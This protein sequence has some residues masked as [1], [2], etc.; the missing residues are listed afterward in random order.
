MRKD[1][2]KS[3]PELAILSG[4][5]KILLNAAADGRLCGAIIHS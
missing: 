1:A 2:V 3:C 5:S 4:P